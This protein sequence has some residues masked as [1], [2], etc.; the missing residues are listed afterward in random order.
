MKKYGI[1]A[2][3]LLLVSA[4]T[5]SESINFKISKTFSVKFAGTD[6]VGIFKTLDG[7]IAFDQDNLSASKCNFTIPVA[8]INTGNGT[9]NKHA[10]SDKWFNAAKYPK[11]QFSS[12]AFKKSSMGYLVSGIMEIH[13]IKKEITIPFTFINDQFVAKFSVNRLD[14]GIG[15]MKGMS[16]KV[17][18]EIKLDITIPVSKI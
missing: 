9:K 5:L 16:K 3:A 2:V 10:V 8:S 12:S 14:Y 1:A 17:S 15:T 4:F 18:N 6:A 7:T 13:G 11:I